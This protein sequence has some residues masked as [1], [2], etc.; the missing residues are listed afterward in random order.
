MQNPAVGLKVTLG[1]ILSIYAPL[2]CIA[3][4]VVQRQAPTTVPTAVA[5]FLQRVPHPLW[6]QVKLMSLGQV[7][8]LVGAQLFFDV[9]D[10]LSG[11]IRASVK[12]NVRQALAAC[13]GC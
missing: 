8:G 9:A 5:L 13:N 12:V 10:V 6:R 1:V 3:P 2:L 7:G 4:L 11:Q